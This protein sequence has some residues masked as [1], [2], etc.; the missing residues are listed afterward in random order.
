MAPRGGH[1]V[2][3]SGICSAHQHHE[4]G[5]VQCEADVRDMFPDYDEKKAE[6]EA[7]G[8]HTCECGFE[9]YRTVGFCP[10]CRRNLP[11]ICS[12]HERYD[13][14]CLGCRRGVQT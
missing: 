6:A 3:V 7:A 14:A 8:L 5:C 10:R 11:G 9:H 13:H 2:L 4:P 1:E 12:S